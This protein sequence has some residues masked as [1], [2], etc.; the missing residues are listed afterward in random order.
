MK[1]LILTLLVLAVCLNVLC[2]CNKSVSITQWDEN[3]EQTDSIESLGDQ[4][5][6]DIKIPSTAKNTGFAIINNVIGEVTFSFNSIVYMY[7]ASKIVSGSQLHKIAFDDKSL[8]EI[9]IGDRAQ[10]KAY[11]ADD[12]GRVAQWYVDGTYYS[13]YTKKGISDDAITEL[14]DLLIA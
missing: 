3:L 4:I 8:S 5:G 12:G 14:C 10:V 9:A 1:R 6:F 13:L 7:R 2:S 11:T